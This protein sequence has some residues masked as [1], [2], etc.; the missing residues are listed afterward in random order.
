M[1]T[2]KTARILAAAL[3]LV[4]PMTSPVPAQVGCTGL[5][6]TG[7]GSRLFA[8]G[9]EAGD[10]GRWGAPKPPGPVFHATDTL[11]IR[12]DVG[13][14]AETTGEHTVEF[15]VILPE[16]N[17]Y[18]S[19]VVPVDASSAVAAST[20]GRR[21][22]VGYPDPVP[23]QAPRAGDGSGE[24]SSTVEESLA[25]DERSIFEGDASF[26]G[27]TRIR[28]AAVEGLPVSGRMPVGGTAITTSSLYGDWSVAV[29]VDGADAPCATSGFT[30]RP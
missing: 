5:V 25:A 2:M 23:V 19:I 14:D 7:D 27:R 30:V 4:V 24:S 20:L 29:H 21:R 13:L 9:F 1:Q 17:L 3:V 6:V 28:R 16:G 11:E 15:R 10:T 18:Q 26:E 12:F 22:L 8:D